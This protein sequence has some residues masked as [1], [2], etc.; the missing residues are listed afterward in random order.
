M[1]KVLITE[2]KPGDIFKLEN[3]GIDAHRIVKSVTVKQVIYSPHT[4]VSVCYAFSDDDSNGMV[5]QTD[6]TWTPSKKVYKVLI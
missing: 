2:L 1:K 5:F 3:S 6:N 4:L